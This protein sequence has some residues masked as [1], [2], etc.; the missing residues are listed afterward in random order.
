MRK[1]NRTTPDCCKYA[2]TYICLTYDNGEGCDEDK[3]YYFKNKPFWFIRGC[4]EY[5]GFWA[6]C[7]DFSLLKLKI[8]FC[9]SCGKKLPE[10]SMKKRLPKKIMTVT[11]GGFY[12]DVCKRRLDSCN[13]SKPWALWEINK[14]VK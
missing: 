11:D 1:I 2:Q 12:C 5:E 14:K 13:C 7:R 10:L 3:D 6:D 9:P 4:K 8:E